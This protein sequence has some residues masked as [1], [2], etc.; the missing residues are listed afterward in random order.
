LP[1]IATFEGLGTLVTGASAGIGREIALEAARRKARLVLSARRL[2]RLEELAEECRRLGAPEVHVEPA[3]LARREEVEALARRS[4][5]ALGSVDVVVANA[6]FGLAGL[7]E[8]ASADRMSEMLDVNV[9]ATVLLVRALLPPMLRAGRGGV[10][11]VSSMA[12]ILPAPFQAAYAGTKAYLLNWAESLHQEAKDRGV[13][14]TALCPGT[15]DTEFFEVSGYRS[16]SKYLESRMSPVLVAR[17]GLDGLARGRIRVVPGG[18]NR[19]LVFL[20][21][22]LSPRR[23]VGAV[24]RRLM[25][26]RR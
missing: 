11:V 7:F 3:D 9:R 15:T 2:L 18:K 26:G 17:A 19:F 1:K 4:A 16:T 23:L 13:V 10:L 14:V 25:M 20:G 6:G 24:S 22:R 12:G 8:R 5:E 21:T